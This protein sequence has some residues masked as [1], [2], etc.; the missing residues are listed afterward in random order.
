MVQIFLFP[1]LDTG[2]ATPMGVLGHRGIDHEPQRGLAPAAHPAHDDHV[3][4]SRLPSSSLSRALRASTSA[5][6]SRTRSF[7]C[8]WSYVYP[9]VLVTC[10]PSVLPRHSFI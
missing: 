5:S 9:P 10:G 4:P 8:R 1:S 2:R 3:L 7:R 6:N